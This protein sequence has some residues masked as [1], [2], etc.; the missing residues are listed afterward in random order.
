MKKI[1]DF[2]IIFL[3]VFLLVNFFNWEKK[4]SAKIKQNV[5]VSALSNSYTIPADVKIK[6]ENNTST[7]I[8]LNTC[9]NIS[10]NYLWAVKKFDNNFCKDIKIKPKSTKIIDFSKEYEK[11][12][13]I[14]NYIITTKIWD[15]S[16]TS[17]VDIENKWTIKKIFVYL[18]YAPAYNLMVILINLFN[19][20]LGWSIIAITILLRLLL[21]WPQ[22][23]M[24]VS[25]KKLQA[26]QPKI[27]ELQEK[28][29][30]NHQMLWMKTMELYKKEKV[31]PMW[32]CGFMLIQMPI[33]LV[34][35]NIILYIKD[36]S[37][38]YYLYNFLQNFDFWSINYYFFW[39]DLLGKWWITWIILGVF[40]AILQFFQVK[41]SMANNKLNNKKGI[42]LEKKKW[43]K[44]YNSMMPDPE[45][46]NKVMLFG[47]PVMVW[48]FTYQFPAWLGIYWG[49][50]TTFMIVQQLVVNNKLK[51][52]S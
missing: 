26:L 51:K 33:L 23:K 25:Q 39:I 40:V 16:Y 2:I 1:L 12:M 21:L 19:N 3:L 30:W 8:I 44:D 36:S 38:H 27:K 42:V 28:H 32:S 48:F 37:N 46:M 6:I 17:S 52:S 29:K 45:M 22:H 24:M 7:W 14:G 41:L 11:F 43:A 15:K 47:M 31:N 4:D 10:I 50:S 5:I 18:F 9:K 13:N 20:S 35:Y 34:I 49:I